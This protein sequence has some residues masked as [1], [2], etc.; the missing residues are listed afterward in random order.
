V[1]SSLRIDAPRDQIAAM[2]RRLR[3]TIPVVG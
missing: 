1:M 3:E 2:F